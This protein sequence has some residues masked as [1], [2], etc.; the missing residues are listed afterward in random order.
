MHPGVP[1]EI[2]QSLDE[3]LAQINQMTEMVE[4]L[5]TLARADEGRAPLAVEESDLR[6][7]VGDVAETAGMLGRSVGDHRDERHARRAGAPG[8][9]PAPDQGDAAQSGHQRDQVHALG[10]HGR[11]GPGR[12]GRRGRLHR[13]DTGSASPPAICRTSSTGSGEPTRP[14]RAPASVPAPASDSRSPSGSRRRT[15]DPSRCRA[16]PGGGRCS[17]CGCRARVEH[18]RRAGQGNGPRRCRFQPE[19]DSPSV[20]PVTQPFPAALTANPVVTELSSSG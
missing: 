13:R 17:R 8:G 4:N 7:L 2:L 5:L 11:A 3:T 1:A 19:L 10:R 9:R 18:A 12:G 20:I 15:A 6:D 16:G 14:A